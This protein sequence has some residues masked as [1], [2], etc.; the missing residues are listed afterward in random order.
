MS[1]PQGGKLAAA[2]LAWFAKHKRALPWRATRDPYRIW[3]SEVMLQQTQAATVIPFYEGFLRRFPDLA[4]LAAADDAALMKAWEGLGYYAR[5][6]NLRAAAQT[7]LREYG[8]RLPASREVLLKLPGFGPYTSAAVASLAFGA[9]C[10]AVDGNVMRVLARV[11]A[12]DTDIRKM[13]TRRRLQQLADDLI[14]A[15]RA[16]EFNEALMELGALVCRPKN[17]ACEACPI[18]RFCRAFQ[19]GRA[20]ELPVKSRGP[21]VPH[22]EIAIGVVR[23]RGKVLIAL[24][25]AE[26]LLG[27]LWEFPGGKRHADETLAECCRREIKEETGLDIE[28]AETFAIVPHAYTHFRITL[29]AFH[30]RYTGGRAEPRTSQAIRWVRLNE[31]DDYAFPKANKQI[32]AALRESIAARE[33]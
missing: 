19:E 6:R 13:A 10:A 20:R 17:P 29:H 7:I 25:P 14:P 27:N 15:G 28:V 9:D 32:I 8:G 12:V 23:R 18:H 26:G 3:V 24:R 5:A 21:A 30:C 2:L 11:Y 33:S 16:G 31:L 4:A 1:R 22:H